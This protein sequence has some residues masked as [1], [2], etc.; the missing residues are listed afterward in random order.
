[1]DVSSALTW[2]VIDVRLALDMGT[3]RAMDR[4]GRW[5]DPG[6]QLGTGIVF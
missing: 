3:K 5:L 4:D 2:R 1:V 6:I